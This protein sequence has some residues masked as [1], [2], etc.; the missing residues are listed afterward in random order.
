LFG[1]F[2]CR[3]PIHIHQFLNADLKR[4]GCKVTDNPTD[5][6]ICVSREDASQ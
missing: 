2:V 4:T 1:E 3:E 5:D 6:Y